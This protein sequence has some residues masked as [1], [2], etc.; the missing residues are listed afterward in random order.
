MI[1]TSNTF[2]SKASS[3]YAELA[4]SY[5]V[6]F[7]LFLISN[8]LSMQCCL[9]VLYQ[10]LFIRNLRE[11]LSNHII[12][13][14]LLLDLLFE[15]TNIPFIIHYYRRNGIWQITRPFSQIWSFLSF[16]IYPTKTIVFAWCTIERHI[17]VFHHRLLLNPRNRFV[18]HYLPLIIVPLY[19]LIYYSLI[20]FYPFCDY[21][22][23]QSTLNGVYTPCFLIDPI[24]SKYDLIVNQIIPVL[25]II[26]F[27]LGLFFRFQ[28]QKGRLR[29]SL[30]WRKQRKL[31]I[32][33]LS[34]FIIFSGFQF[35]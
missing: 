20:I 11:S 26:S 27:T 14:L 12:I 15:C 8:M 17:L 9:F 22:Y 19:G 25:I 34:I 18:L 3:A 24:L 6:R 21:L 4:I 23:S 31:I 5:P 7:W 33:V 35:P 16:G 29:Q 10:L 13:V 1:N 32:Q 28:L 2:D 30:E